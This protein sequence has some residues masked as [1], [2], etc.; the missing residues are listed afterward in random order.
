MGAPNAGLARSRVGRGLLAAAAAGLLLTACGGANASSDSAGSGAAPAVAAAPAPATAPGTAHSD[1]VA[2]AAAQQSAPKVGSSGLPVLPVLPALLDRSVIR[3]ASIEVRVSN[4][5]DSAGRAEA[6]AASAG[7]YVAA[8]QTQADP[9]HPDQSSAVVTL[10]IPGTSLPQVL[11]GLAHMGA[12]LSQDQSS[13]DVTG[14]VID[15]AARLASQQASVDRIRALLAQ[16]TTI[17]EVVSIEGEL[18]T[19]EGA[20]ESLQA[21]AKALA[22]QTSLA[23]VTATLVGPQAAVVAPPAP[24][25]PRKGFASGLSQGWAAFSAATTWLLTAVGAALPFAVLAAVAAWLA[26]VVRRRRP[27]GPAGRDDAEPDLA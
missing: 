25:A 12:L 7:G 10:R 1:V 14:Q 2:G 13:T 24:P 22:D 15:V 16:A 11:T 3:T 17:G 20:L 8:E 6:L 4:V 27:A 5:L 9:D 26:L 21:Q 19:R 18:A 23:T